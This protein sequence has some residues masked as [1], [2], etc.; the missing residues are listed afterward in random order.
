MKLSDFTLTDLTRFLGSKVNPTNSGEGSTDISNQQTVQ[1]TNQQQLVNG[2]KQHEES[3]T[4]INSSV[5]P[6]SEIHSSL[7][8]EN[9]NKINQQFGKGKY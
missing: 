1:T 4:R 6:T 3:V 9:K 5:K 8:N 7:L 2:D